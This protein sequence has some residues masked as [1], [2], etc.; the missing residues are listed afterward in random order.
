MG[1]SFFF[2]FLSFLGLCR[3]LSLPGPR[4]WIS[5]GRLVT[6]DGDV[7]LSC[8]RRSSS[9]TPRTSAELTSLRTGSILGSLSNR[10]SVM[11]SIG[12]DSAHKAADDGGG[13]LSTEGAGTNGGANGLRL[14]RMIVTEALVL[15]F[16]G[17]P[18]DRLADWEAMLVECELS[19]T[20]TSSEGPRFRLLAVE[21]E[22]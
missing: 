19:D 10:W 11:L 8:S 13:S 17:G 7:A 9:V 16:E 18:D 15:R 2:L 5:H 14:D 1:K 22:E 20:D 4:L 21:P 12:A 3:L 6:G